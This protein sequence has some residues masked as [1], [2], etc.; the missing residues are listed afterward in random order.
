MN[1]KEEESM[2]QALREIM[3]PELKQS[4][5]EGMEKGMKKGLKKGILATVKS[6]RE[7]GQREEDIKSI[8]VRNFELLP[9]E[10]EDYMIS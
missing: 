4:M 3:E 1:D 6:L 2:C 8:I 9:A 5:K 10:A 7:V